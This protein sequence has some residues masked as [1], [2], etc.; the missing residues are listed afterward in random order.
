MADR[1]PTEELFT[2]FPDVSISIALPPEAAYKKLCE[3]LA[4]A[5]VEYT[6]ESYEYWS[7]ATGNRLEAGPTTDLF[8][9]ES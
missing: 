7:G 9:T 8:P 3:L 6:T 2:C 4:A 1:K 5:G